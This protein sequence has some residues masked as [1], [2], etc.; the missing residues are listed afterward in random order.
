MTE[1]S[2]CFGLILI[3]L[4]GLFSMTVTENAS[5]VSLA[6]DHLLV[7]GKNLYSSRPAL[8][9]KGALSGPSRPFPF[10]VVVEKGITSNSS[11]VSCNLHLSDVYFFSRL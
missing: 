11:A 9:E 10:F 5:P 1:L 2:L 8:A 4:Y 6:G 7:P 3:I